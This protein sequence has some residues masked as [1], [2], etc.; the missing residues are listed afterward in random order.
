MAVDRRIFL[1]GSAALASA[2][3]LGAVAA[4][5]ETDVAIIGAGAAGIAAARKVAAAGRR[6]AL[7]E[8]SDRVGGRCFTESRSFGVPYDRGAHWLHM[9]D[10]NPLAKLSP[11]GSGLDVYSA[12]PGQKLR[13]ARRNARE[14][15]MEDYLASIVRANR[16]IQDSARGKSD[17]SCAQALPK[18]L[19]A[20]RESVEFAL[21]PFGCGKNL[22]DVSA[23]DFARSLE[24]DI[25]AFC[26]QGL[27]ALVA[28]LAEGIPVQ[29]RMPVTQ[30]HSTR[31]TVEI[32]T[33]RGRIHA[34]AAIVTV[35]T[36]VLL[37]DRIKFA[38]ALPK[39]QIDALAKLSL[40][41]YDHVAL[42]LATNPLQLRN[43]DLVFEKA[44][45]ARTAA[46]LAN[47]SGTP[48]CMIEVGGKFGAELSQSGEAAMI[49]FATGWLA[50]LFGADVKKAIGRKHAT[51]WNAEPFALG[52]FSAAGVGGQGGRKILMEPVRDRLFFA[53]EAVHETL[54]GTAGGAW[55][56][57]ER[58]AEAA[59]KLWG[60]RR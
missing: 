6:F 10:L 55:E 41:S 44:S 7:I 51:R 1:A 19:G 37:A 58:A 3:A 9:P 24:R 8:A 50:D 29:L 11:R 46:L 5:G 57:G 49:D 43:D 15:E 60:G 40:G 48:L 36:G 32:E 59:L 20:W 12:P 54:W 16:A 42:E 38:P 30:L 14:G 39:R 22:D 25:D 18:D 28:R 34:R 35:S 21:G 4:A 2:P 26:R 17:M 31:N 27:G 52:A 56:S 47:V 45:G 33:A 13:I 53:G 23:M